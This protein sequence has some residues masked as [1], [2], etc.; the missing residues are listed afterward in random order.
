MGSPS[1]YWRLVK[2]DI[3][4]QR[5]VEEV[6]DAKHFFQ[7]QFV[8]FAGQ[9][10]V[11]D[12]FIQRQC[13]NL[14]RRVGNIEGDRP[15]HLAEV[16]MRCF[17]SNQIDGICQR[18]AMQFGSRHGFTH[19]D[20][21]P[22]VLDD[23]VSVTRRSSSSYRSL[24]TKILDSYDPDKAGLSTWVHR[25][26]RGQD[27]LEQFLLEQGVYLISDWAILNDTQPKA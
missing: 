17:I 18:L 24:A 8:Q 13:V 14:I 10:D 5:Q 27:E 19:H 3:T 26:V 9:F 25:L 15:A 11:P 1:R 23:V 4:G 7:Q 21:L 6:A 22:Y 2:L 12:A 16:C 20:L